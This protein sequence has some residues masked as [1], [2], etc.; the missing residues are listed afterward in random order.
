MKRSGKVKIRRSS[1]KKIKSLRYS[2]IPESNDSES[3]PQGQFHLSFPNNVSLA[4]K[5]SLAVGTEK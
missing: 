1:T 5:K 3:L 2:T 4:F